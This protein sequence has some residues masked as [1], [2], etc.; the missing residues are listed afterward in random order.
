VMQVDEG[1]EAESEG[2]GASTSLNRETTLFQF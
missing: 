2:P 1:Y